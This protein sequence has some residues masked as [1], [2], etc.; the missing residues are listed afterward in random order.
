MDWTVKELENFALSIY[1][2]K[3]QLRQHV[4]KRSAEA[5]A[6]GDRMRDEIVTREQLENRREE[7]R[8]AFLEGIG[9]LPASEAPL[10]ATVT[11]HVQLEGMRIDA[12][13]YESRPNT[14]VTASLYVPDG[15]SEPT[16]AVLFVCG[17]FEEGRLAPNYQ[18]VCQTI[19]SRGLLVLAIDPLG[20]G[21]RSGYYDHAT[22]EM[23]V[24][25]STSDHE[26]A[27]AQC[28]PLG[29]GLARYFL[30][31]I[32]RAID[33]LQTR[34]D[35]DP[36]RIGITGNSGGGLQTTMAMLTDR[37]IAAAAPATFV[38]NRESYLYAGQGQDAEQIWPGMSAKG[39]DHEDLLMAMA[40]RPV[41]V[42]AA[43]YDF[44]PIEGTRRTVERSKR[45]WEMYGK[46]KLA[47]LELYEDRCRHCYSEG[48]AQAAAAFF[49]ERFLGRKTVPSVIESPRAA[50]DNPS[51]EPV[52]AE[53]LFATS[54]GQVR[55]HF[56]GER[57]PWEENVDR[58][59]EWERLRLSIPDQ[60][61]KEAA[62]A[63]LEQT[64][65]GNRK[66]AELNPRHLPLG[67][68]DGLEIDS[69]LWWSQEG[70]HNHAFLFRDGANE[71]GKQPLIIAVWERGTRALSSRMK[72]IK[73]KTEAGHAVMVLDVS[74][75]GVVTPNA[76][77]PRGLYDSFG[78]LHKLTTDLLFLGDSL[79]AI[80]AYDVLRSV[81][82]AVQ[83]D[84]IAAE[85]IEI[86]GEGGFSLYTKLAQALDRERRVR[87]WTFSG[88]FS[89]V[90]DW[91]NER[92][93]VQYDVLS[94]VL[95]GM[96]RHFDLP[97][98]AWWADA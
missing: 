7:A 68:I 43:Q 60:E 8:E 73:E 88:G 97:D 40:P 14:H 27:G 79:A 13:I 82:M 32:V 18:A 71:G 4:Y 39:F 35:V 29:D 41:L 12:L 69:W 1:D 98:L 19:A 87:K 59:R 70:L 16:G 44:F 6:A 85:T 63:W 64:V 15:L 31:D 51:F 78:T 28:W 46:G 20:Q 92:H 81:D 86:Y 48:M 53:K 80:R 93:Y 33:Y 61:R 21:E 58:A 52:D 89:R 54:S 91:L 11:G 34:P 37:R 49:A 9:G 23:A 3:D 74:G 36:A 84:H 24:P 10:H 96:L 90:E 38:M 95:P 67:T 83:P 56:A 65:M 76:I 55:G 26:Q 30:H 17:H 2:V 57:G 94:T 25:R 62:L 42:L 45:F 5:F 66:A 77:S 22:G 47:Q 75:E 72:W 50:A